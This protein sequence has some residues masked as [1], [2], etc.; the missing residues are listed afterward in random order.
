M[1]QLSHSDAAITSHDFGL[2]FESVTLKIMLFSPGVKSLGLILLM[3][4]RI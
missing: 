1:F 2:N 3:I 4:L